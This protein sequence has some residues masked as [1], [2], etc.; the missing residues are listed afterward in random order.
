[1]MIGM[2]QQNA[3]TLMQEMQRKKNISSFRWENA[4]G[5]KILG[6]DKC[7]SINSLIR[8]RFKYYF[9]RIFCGY[10]CT[11]EVYKSNWFKFKLCIHH[12]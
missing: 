12:G 4:K 6:T 3:L 7:N 1:M 2:K 11:K 8:T 9:I 5:R 10:L